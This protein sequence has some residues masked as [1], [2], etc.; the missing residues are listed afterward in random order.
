M[1]A[2]QLPPE[3]FFGRRVQHFRLDLR[4]FRRP[5]NEEDLRLLA[6]FLVLE[7][8][9]NDGIPALGFWQVFLELFKGGLRENRRGLR[10]VHSFL[11]TIVF[12]S[13]LDVRRSL[14][15]GP[16]SFSTLTMPVCSSILKMM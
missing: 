7:R 2:V 5:A 6:S 9:V 8:V 11:G 4:D 14:T 10:S 12:L 1:H 16:A 13:V 3:L 15:L